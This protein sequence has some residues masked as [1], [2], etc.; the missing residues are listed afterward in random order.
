MIPI[1][2]ARPKQRRM[3]RIKQNK[4]LP[5]RH[6][7]PTSCG[8]DPSPGAPGPRSLD[9]SRRAASRAFSLVELVV[10]IGILAV[11]IALT[12]QIF[13]I[14]IDSTG[15]ATAI[16]DI[17]QSVRMLEE[18]LREDLAGVDPERSMLVIWSQPINAYW[19]RAQQEIDP[20]SGN[21]TQGYI[22]NPDPEREDN[23]MTTGAI[24]GIAGSPPPFRLEDPRADILMFFTARRTR[25]SNYPQVFADQA[26]VVY[27]H[28]ELGEIDPTDPN[29][30]LTVANAYP[31][32]VTNPTDYFPVP[33]QDWHLARRSIALVESPVA[34][35]QAVIE[36][37]ANPIP[38]WLAP[39]IS[40]DDDEA[41]DLIN[42]E[43]DF[44]S[45]VDPGFDFNVNIVEEPANISLIAI[46]AWMARSRLDLDPPGRYADRL[47][48]FFLNNCASFKVEWALE[49]PAIAGNAQVV[50]V[51]PGDI[52]GSVV[53]Q[54]SGEPFELMPGEVPLDLF[55]AGGA[56]D[57]TAANANLHQFD[58]STPIFPRALRITVDLF[59]DNDRFERPVRHVMI[60]PVG[61]P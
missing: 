46:Q 34:A 4:N 21:P 27:G 43:I 32:F 56:F 13:S 47:G 17:N 38:D 23:D 51:D 3:K 39:P 45:S 48:H 50:W 28:A 20:A 19:T 60:L 16:I 6:D 53:M 9:P 40:L 54:L 42:G 36:G 57:P 58:N 31:D 22:H 1:G 37:N 7:P 12:G 59:D 55:E 30:A 44:I 25:S 52:A 41:D 5:L 61:D 15:E 26:Q 18:T 35:L 11:M 2:G 10:A 33:A 29:G 49:D 8:L 24:A 14:S